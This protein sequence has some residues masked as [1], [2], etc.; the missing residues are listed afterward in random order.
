MMVEVKR[1]E[2]DTETS[3]GDDTTRHT[4]KTKVQPGE[5]FFAGKVTANINTSS[6]SFTPSACK[7]IQPMLDSEKTPSSDSKGSAG[8]AAPS[9]YSSIVDPHSP[10]G[11]G[12]PQSQPSVSTNRSISDVDSAVQMLEAGSGVTVHVDLDERVGEYVVKI[13]RS[14]NSTAENEHKLEETKQLAESAGMLLVQA[15]V[16][17][18]MGEQLLVKYRESVQRVIRKPALRIDFSP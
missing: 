8:N 17:R 7:D 11:N 9:N 2:P 3:P 15:E 12:S 13:K 10:Q 18:H 4:K 5:T 14:I 6:P 1:K 16:L